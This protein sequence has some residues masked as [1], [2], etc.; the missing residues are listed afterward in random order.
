VRAPI[1]QPEPEELLSER[2]REHCRARLAKFKVPLRFE[3]VDQRAQATQ[4][5][6]ARRFQ[7]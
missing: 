1:A 7:G 2:L 4:R 6:K 3:V 5:K